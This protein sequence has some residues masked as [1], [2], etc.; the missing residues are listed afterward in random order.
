MWGKVTHVQAAC[1]LLPRS[2]S[3]GDWAAESRRRE[4]QL[5]MT[6]ERGAGQ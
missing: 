4:R 5:A 2:L 3:R 1:P 6:A